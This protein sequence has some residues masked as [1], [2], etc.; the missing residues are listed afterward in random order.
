MRSAA[1][2]EFQQHDRVQWQDYD[3]IA[4]M[5]YVVANL[6]VQYLVRPDPNSSTGECFVFKNNPTLK[7]SK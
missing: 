2:E 3:G 1:K 5:G 4:R 6:S 7:R